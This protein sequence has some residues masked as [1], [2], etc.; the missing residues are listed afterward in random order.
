MSATG[1]VA[2]PV[3]GQGRLRASAFGR[4]SA[5]L[6]A[7][8]R[9]SLMTAGT[10]GVY[11]FWM[12]TRI[13]RRLWSSV[14]LGGVPFEYTGTPVEKL[15]GFAIAAA[16]VG[17]W[18]GVVVMVL[19]WAALHLFTDPTPGALTAI[20]LLVP[21]YFAARYRGLRYVLS[22][23]QWRGLPF[24]MVPGAW[25]YA[26]RATLWTAAALATAGLLIPARARALW[27]F[28]AERTRW[29]DAPF[30]YVAP[31][32]GPL[33]GAFAPVAVAVGAVAAGAA[34]EIAAAVVVGMVATPFAWA[35][36]RVWGFR[37]LIG[38]LRLGDARLSVPMRFGRIVA[39]HLLGWLGVLGLLGVVG[40]A[41]SGLIALPVAL[42][43]SL[44]REALE[45]LPGYAL[46]AAVVAVYLALFVLRGTLSLALVTWPLIRHGAEV[47]VVSGAAGLD[48]VR[49]DEGAP[50]AD[51]DGFANLFDFG[52][53]I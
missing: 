11:G 52:G 51:A 4:R 27:R 36:W 18:L 29:G 53:G 19:V 30:G 1:T 20:A 48:E 16:T 28:R 31:G 23:T 22:R 42:E 9:W 50:M 13:R 39:I 24:W 35:Y 41:A 33:Y 10:L 3:V 47:A 34:L 6:G 43:P 12:R 37:L 26:W 15:A 32:L 46:A 7:A 44:R 21:I 40:A 5:L 49:R 17:V 14:S 8:L 45:T 25:G 2:V 38:G